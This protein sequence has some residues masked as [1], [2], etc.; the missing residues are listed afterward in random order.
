[1]TRD[2]LLTHHNLLQRLR[3]GYALILIATVDSVLAVLYLRRSTDRQEKSIQDQR[4]ALK[5]YAVA[6]GYK[7]VGEYV[8]DA[9]SGDKTEDRDRV[10]YA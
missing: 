4:S 8:D 1:M 2:R 10:S 6:H 7:I 9:I 5:E 3:Y